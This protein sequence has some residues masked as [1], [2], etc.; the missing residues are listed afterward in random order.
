[1][2]VGNHTSASNSG[3]D[4]CVQFFITADGQ[5]KVA[6]GDALHLKILAGVSSQ[7]EDLSGEVFE[8]SCGVHGRGG[9]HTAVGAHSALEESVDAAHRELKSIS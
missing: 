3:L 6:R 1:M 7:F 5:L 9:A 4:K 8:N 2:D